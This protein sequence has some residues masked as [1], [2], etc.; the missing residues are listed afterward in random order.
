MAGRGGTQAWL[1]LANRHDLEEPSM[2]QPSRTSSRGLSG[3]Q[4]LLL[5]AAGWHVSSSLES[6]QR[7][8]LPLRQ[9]SRP[10][11]SSG[12]HSESS[13]LPLQAVQQQ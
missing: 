12:Q 2:Q 3:I 6:F 8:A 11:S 7:S 4:H 9:C 13:V 5:S 10:C 1:G